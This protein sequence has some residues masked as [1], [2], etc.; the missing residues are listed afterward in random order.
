MRK[1]LNSCPYCIFNRTEVAI[2]NL[3]AF[4]VDYFK[5]IFC[6]NVN[7]KDLFM[8]CLT[9]FFGV[10]TSVNRNGGNEKRLHWTK[11]PTEFP[12]PKNS[13][14]EYSHLARAADASLQDTFAVDS[15]DGALQ[16]AILASR[17]QFRLDNAQRRANK[18]LDTVPE[19]SNAIL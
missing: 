1:V 3:F 9:S 6:S 16:K 12:I 13:Q 18:V 4:L 8:G 10:F 19:D 15:E 11:R 2:F 14:E 7:Q 17:K 5:N